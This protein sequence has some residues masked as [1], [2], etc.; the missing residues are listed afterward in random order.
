MTDVGASK[1]IMSKG[2]FGLLVENTE[3]GILEGMKS[4]LNNPTSIKQ[5][6][7]DCLHEESPFSIDASMNE[8]EDLFDEIYR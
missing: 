8:V 3:D 6:S 2:T 7:H 1:E 4:Y 5:Y